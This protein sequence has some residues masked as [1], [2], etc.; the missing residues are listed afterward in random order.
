MNSKNTVSDIFRE[1]EIKQFGAN[2]QAELGKLRKLFL[3]LQV[4]FDEHKRCT[5]C[6]HF[7]KEKEVCK[8]T[9]GPQFP[10]G[11]RPPA[12]VIVKGCVNW[13]DIPF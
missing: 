7:D 3:T 9:I 1:Q 4:I 8:L 2:L 6:C 10:Q 12:E 5:D 11:V 13:D